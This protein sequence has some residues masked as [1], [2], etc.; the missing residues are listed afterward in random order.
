MDDSNDREYS[1]T[2]ELRDVI[3]LCRS[4]NEH[5]VKYLLIG[6]FAVILYGYSR[7][8]KDIDFLIDPSSENVQKIKKAMSILMDNTISQI[9]DDE[10]EIFKVVRLA[11]EV[12]VDLMAIA[13]GI[14]WQEASLSVQKIKV[15]DVEIPI[16]DKVTLVKTK[17]TVRPSDKVDVSFLMA[18]IEEENKLL[19][20][21]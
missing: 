9:D 11:D 10:V 13:C 20:R 2:P 19:R 18:L 16:A 6:G 14:T 17:D 8:T 4:M 15:D 21:P 3:R 7:G 12:V 1:R 5:G